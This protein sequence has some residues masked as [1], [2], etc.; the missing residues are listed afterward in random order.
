MDY[1]SAIAAVT[2]G[3][4]AWRASWTSPYAWLFLNGGVVYFYT[5]GSPAGSPYSAPSGDQAATNW[6]SGDHPPHP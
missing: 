2:A 6:D 4:Y 3:K 5:A 1:A